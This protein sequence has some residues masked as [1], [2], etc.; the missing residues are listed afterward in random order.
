M[1][2]CLKWLLNKF[3]YGVDAQYMWDIYEEINSEELQSADLQIAIPFDSIHVTKDKTIIVTVLATGAFTINDARNI[4]VPVLADDILII[5]IT[6]PNWEKSKQTLLTTIS[7]GLGC[8]IDIRYE[9]YVT[10]DQLRSFVE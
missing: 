2:T 3:V 10:D 4:K 6:P 8:I 1:L 9:N 5:T 7:E